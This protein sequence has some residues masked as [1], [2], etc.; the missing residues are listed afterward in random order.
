MNIV[1]DVQGVSRIQVLARAA[2]GELIFDMAVSTF[3]T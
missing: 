1:L 3:M 2:S